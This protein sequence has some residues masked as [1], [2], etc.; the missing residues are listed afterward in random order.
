MEAF[1]GDRKSELG[2]YDPMGNIVFAPFQER[3]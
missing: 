2:I 1:K 3:Q